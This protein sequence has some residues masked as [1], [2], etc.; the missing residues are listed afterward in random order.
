MGGATNTLT[1]TSSSPVG[2]DPTASVSL[3]ATNGT[4]TTFMRSDAAPPLSQSIAPTWTGDHYFNGGYVSIGVAKNTD[5]RFAALETKSVK[6]TDGHLAVGGWFKADY[7]PDSADSNNSAIGTVQYG[8]KSGSYA[9]N[10]AVLY[11]T[12]IL[13]PGIVG[14]YLVG[15]NEG[16]GAVLN[17]AG[18]VTQ[19]M[20]GGAGDITNGYGL[21]CASPSIWSTGIIVNLYGIY[22]AAQANA[23]VTNPYAIYQEGSSDVSIFKGTLRSDNKLDLK[24]G[25]GALIVHTYAVTNWTDVTTA[26]LTNDGDFAVVYASGESGSKRRLY[27]RDGANFYYVDFS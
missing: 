23:Y 26:V 15:V 2:A 20:N 6:I 16:A 7:S 17:A 4:A 14:G 24:T 19:M 25:S 22:I 1:Y 13:F 12:S 18:A 8:H 10:T 9:L 3:T 27:K 21:L 5:F 11:S